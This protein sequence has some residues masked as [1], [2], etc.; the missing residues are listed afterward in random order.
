MQLNKNKIYLT[1]KTNHN[2]NKNCHSN[3]IIGY[4]NNENECGGTL[5]LANVCF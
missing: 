5:N 1:H 2:S 3:I 4:N